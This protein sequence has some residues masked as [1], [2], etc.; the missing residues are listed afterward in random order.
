MSANIVGHGNHSSR[1]AVWV[2]TKPTS[3]FAHNMINLQPDG[4]T[5]DV[6][7]YRDPKKGV[8]NNQIVD[9]SF[10]LDGVLHNANQERVYETV[11]FDVVRAAL[12]GYSGTIM[13]Y[14]QTGAGKTFTMTG[15][16]E[17]YKHRGLIPRA[18]SQLFRDIDERPDYAI[19][20]RISYMEIYNEAMCDLL[21]TLPE[22]VKA[23]QLNT[24]TIAEDEQGVY[25]K[26]LQSHMV[27][28]EEEAL[29][30]LF[31]GETNRA[32]AA[33]TLNKQS[34]RSHCIF[35]IF[36]ESRSRVESNAKYTLS[37][38]NFVDLAGSERLGKTQSEGKTKEEAMHINKSLSFLE[39]VVL[40]LAD[41]RREHVPFRQ[42]KLTHC[43]KDSI[44]GK[45]YT[46]LVANI[47]G[48]AVQIEETV[49]TLRF[50]TR[51]MCVA[52]E[53]AVNVHYNPNI[54]VKNLEKELLLL[55]RELAMHDTLVNRTQI[56]Y[57]PLT[58][59]Q[60]YEIRQQVRQYLEGGVNEI[61]VINLRQIQGVFE[62]FKDISN[63]LARD[64]EERLRARYT[65]I[66][67]TDPAAI[68]AAQQAG[69]PINSAGEL[70]GDTDPS[71]FGVGPASPSLKPAPSSIVNARRNEIRNRKSRE[72]AS[73]AMKQVSPTQVAKPSVTEVPIAQT[74]S[75]D[76]ED[77]RE[78]SESQST[79]SRPKE[80]TSPPRPSTPPGRMEAFEEFKRDEGSEINRILTENKEILAAKKLSYT[81]LAK[82]INS[83]KEEMD[84]SLARLAK[85]KA[86][87][88]AR[89]DT[90][91]EDGDIVISE[92]EYLEIKRLKDLK[93][94]YRTS[95]DELKTIKSE[96]QYC[97]KLVDQC[98]QKLIQEFDAWYVRSYLS[99][100]QEE[101]QR[102]MIPGPG[103][104]MGQP[105]NQKMK[106]VVD[107][108][109]ERFDQL[110]M[111][112]LM[113]NPDSAS[114]YNAQMRTKQRKIYQAAASQY[115]Q[116]HL[117]G[118][119][120]RTI[121]NPPPTV[122]E[123]RY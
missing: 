6:H 70:V 47:W 51:M 81:S 43:L 37:K 66:D 101:T 120:R 78:E 32:I 48:E 50:A 67:K 89:G 114:F 54:M 22:S 55:K 45:C 97:Q 68:A 122:L 49:S 29:N 41:K 87:R 88:E 13:C 33:H 100:V 95:F 92:T 23:T 73:P 102:S 94:V 14:G 59:Q 80:Q 113:E 116:K 91:N 108:E 75:V 17:N 103:G 69:I 39:Q 65:L 9:W 74:P 99:G 31:E 64:I 46:R 36:I 11:A 62:A 35:T 30:L 104:Q 26:G 12:D 118:T 52:I 84:K 115:Q 19:N 24:L 28:N 112:L 61:D 5:I 58:E 63:Q 86:D 60:R 119:P 93:A 10:K 38:L 3:N 71:G 85:L 79:I 123:V 72:R 90:V 25:V 34:S 18:L 1:A 83:T 77:K 76:K 98:R 27:Q 57:D 42:S 106:P 40:A 2:R 16:T 8:V 44:G 53:P 4:K 107:D 121:R 110:Q 20:L 21:S 117:P 109:Q 96:V 82:E 111:A 15:A 7:C 105:S 56:T